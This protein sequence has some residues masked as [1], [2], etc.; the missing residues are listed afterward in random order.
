MTGEFEVRLEGDADD[1]REVYKANEACAAA[2]LFAEAYEASHH[3]YP[4]ASGDETLR[5]EVR[6]PTGAVVRYV[7]EGETVRQYWARLV[8]VEL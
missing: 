6:T 3:R 2:E 7:V 5:V 4:V 1:E 8:R